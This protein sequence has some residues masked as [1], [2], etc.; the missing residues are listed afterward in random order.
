MDKN[1]FDLIV[2]GA[3]HAG[4]EA[5]LASA[6]LGISTLV[7]TLSIKT[8]ADMSC[9]PAIGGIA[10]G[11]LVKEIDALSGEMAHAIDAS[12]IQYRTLNASKG[13]AV[14]ATRAQADRFL[15]A[16]QLRATL[17]NTENIEV[18]E[19]LVVDFLTE[20]DDNKLVVRGVLLESG[21][22]IKAKAVVVTTGTFLNA[23]M[24]T[25]D[26]VTHGGRVGDGTSNALSLALK[27]LKLNL[28]RLKT[29]TCP[30]L[31]PN[32]INF[33]ILERQ[34][35]DEDVVPFSFTNTSTRLPQ[36]PCHITHTNELTHRIIRENLDKSPLY[37]GSITG[38]G[39]RYCPSIEDKI[40]KF[41]DRDRHQIFLEPEG[42]EPEDLEPEGVTPEGQSPEGLEDPGFCPLKTPDIY[43]NGLSTSLPEDIQLKFLRTIK[44]LEKVEIA[45]PGYA[46]EYDYI[47]PT[48]LKATLEV[49]SIKGLYSAGQINGTSGYEEAA[50]QGLMAGANAALKILGKPPFVLNRSEAYIG[51]MIDDLVTKGTKEPYRLFTSR[52][53]YRLLLRE[54]NADMRLTEK[55]FKAGL[56]TDETYRVFLKKKEAIDSALE[57]LSSTR[58]NPSP[59]VR[60]RFLKLGLGELRKSSS[61]KDILRR[62]GVGLD[63]LTP[64]L[65]TFK[66]EFK[67]DA[68][69][70]LSPA[71]KYSVEV[72][73]K[74]E[75]YVRRQLEEV[76]RFK[77][78]EAKSIPTDFIYANIHGL[79]SEIREKLEK[80]RPA[81]IGQAGRIPGVTPAAISILMVYL[82]K[83]TMQGN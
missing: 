51:V 59:D 80:I 7:I 39:P 41:P 54:D 2:I 43:P 36:I 62:P 23:L 33:S 27:R 69:K 75:G 10:K 19:G 79:S 14:R 1:T 47:N 20:E 66:D 61:L 30:R 32:T 50:A 8:I 31:D 81:S 22:K 12:A 78:S 16:R 35:G 63:K 4:I 18:R 34:D 72:E 64:F 6:R 65:S 44:G 28:G 52:A 25:G 5:A 46:V 17:L 3:G 45:R 68:L 70:N 15:Y 71:E 58:L 11:H 9:N 13:P 77:A 55:G 24:F 38:T 56:V 53:E 73:V 37:S 82:K 67:L 29:G 26:K 74:Y 76:S 49:K 40:V 60:E 57:I 83:A 21:E 42:L 48:E